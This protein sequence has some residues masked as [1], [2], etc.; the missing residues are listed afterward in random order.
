MHHSK[1]C[2]EPHGSFLLHTHTHT[3][4]HTQHKAAAVPERSAAP[5]GSSQQHVAHHAAHHMLLLT[6]YSTCPPEHAVT[7]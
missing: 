6:C 7:S 2:L 5:W 3:H 4:I 1:D